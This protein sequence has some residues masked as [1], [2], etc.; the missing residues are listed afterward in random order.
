MRRNTLQHGGWVLAPWIAAVMIALPAM[1]ARGDSIGDLVR[2]AGEQE[3]T[4]A[5]LGLVVGLPGT[6]DA[7]EDLTLA[8][9]LFEVL[10]S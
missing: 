9:P 6:G 1:L 5:G 2:I 4:L 10:R 3:N 7:G 8:R